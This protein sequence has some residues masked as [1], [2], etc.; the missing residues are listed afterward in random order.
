M[1]D[2]QRYGGKKAERQGQID[3][4]RL[5]KD[6]HAHELKNDTYLL[7]LQSLAASERSTT[8]RWPHPR[9]GLYVGI[10]TSQ[11]LALGYTIRKSYTNHNEQHL[12]GNQPG[13]KTPYII[14]FTSFSPLVTLIPFSPL[15]I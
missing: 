13:Y 6:R 4:Q 10:E 5:T 14:T 9:E 3:R 8:T 11:T 7:L 2:I 15:P 1:S 12:E